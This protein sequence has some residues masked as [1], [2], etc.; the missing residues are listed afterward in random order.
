MIISGNEQSV[1]KILKNTYNNNKVKQLRGLFN[2]FEPQ[3]INVLY[4]FAYHDTFEQL[5]SI[6][7]QQYKQVRE[8]VTA[9]GKAN[10]LKVREIFESDGRCTIPDTIKAVAY[11]YRES[12][13]F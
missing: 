4:N 3:C 5:Q 12:I 10:V 13:S 7:S 9:T 1:N 8:I 6:P 2:M 11:R